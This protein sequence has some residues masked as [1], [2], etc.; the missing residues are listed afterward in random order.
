MCL[1]LKLERCNVKSAG[2]EV[3][4]E[5]LF[6]GPGDFETWLLR[7]KAA[8]NGGY[9]EKA[10]TLNSEAETNDENRRLAG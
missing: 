2:K 8:M 3:D 4:N 10:E 9:S 5:I 7:R 1:F 6:H